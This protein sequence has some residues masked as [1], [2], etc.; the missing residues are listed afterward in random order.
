MI[1]TL[2]AQLL[3]IVGACALGFFG[4]ASAQ[5]TLSDDFSLD[6]AIQSVVFVSVERI[7]GRSQSYLGIIVSPSLI[8]TSSDAV[9][10]ASSKL[11]IGGDTAT[12]IQEFVGKNL[13]LISYPRGG[14]KPVTLARVIGE[15]GR[16]I[17]FVYKNSDGANVQTATIVNL[18]SE[19]T[20]K[21]GY[22]DSSIAP[23]LI[24]S[25]QAAVFNNCG[26][27]IGFY[28]KSIRSDLATA[29]GL[30]EIL[31]VVGSAG[32]YITAETVCQS[33]STKQ[34]IREDI[35]QRQA[36]EAQARA[37]KALQEVESASEKQAEEAARALEAAENKA[38][39]EVDRVKAEADRLAE[40]AE[41]VAASE[42]AIIEAELR[43]AEER[44]AIR[45]AT[46]QAEL[47]RIREEN[48][49][50]EAD[51]SDQVKQ[52]QLQYMVGSGALAALLALFI[53][54]FFLRSRDDNARQKESTTNN[55]GIAFN[56]S[57]I[58]VIIRGAGLSLKLPEELLIR[59]R[60]VTIGR[61]AAD[62]D[63]VLDTPSISR[64]HLRAILHDNL[65]YIEDLGSA[66]GT[67]LNG[68][69]L[70][71]GQMAALHDNDDLEIADSHFSVEVRPR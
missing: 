21:G 31:A 10:G 64:S 6:D 41:Q 49:A 51:L 40:E 34:K 38:T 12:V 55:E 17:N 43:E 3:L 32:R 71:P 57:G 62:C 19:K 44:A 45:E 4:T 22:F 15:E 18:V 28:D 35:A 52:Q 36:E 58:D 9:S 16:E 25:E 56:E 27:L 20:K 8:L 67:S 60:G 14:L 7:S 54:F 63:F 5:Q 26:E 29:K 33:E 61:S 69:Q 66:N 2:R 11:S 48:A 24:N 13:A 23:T 59:K 70:E 30:D 53:L 1:K 46:N 68:K 50:K 39:L 42:R 65:L 37:A 47:E